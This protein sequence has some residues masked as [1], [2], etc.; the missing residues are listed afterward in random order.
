MCRHILGHSHGNRIATGDRFADGNVIL[1]CLG[2]PALGIGNGHF[3]G[4]GG[5]HVRGGENS[6]GCYIFVRAITIRSRH[7]SGVMGESVSDRERS[8][9][10]RNRNGFKGRSNR[11]RAAIAQF[12]E[13][14]GFLVLIGRR[15]IVAETKIGFSLLMK[16]M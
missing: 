13:L 8:L 2:N 12:I 4:A 11:G 7:D 6:R 5:S 10:A 1:I 15:L 14:N 9:L 3:L 16:R